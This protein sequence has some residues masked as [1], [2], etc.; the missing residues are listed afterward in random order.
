MLSAW[1]LKSSVGVR[2]KIAKFENAFPEKIFFEAIAG[3]Q[4]LVVVME[5]EGVLHGYCANLELN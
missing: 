4:S 5:G 3:F 2:E 1:N